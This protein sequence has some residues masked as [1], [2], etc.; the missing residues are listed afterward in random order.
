MSDHSEA[1]GWWLASDGKWYAPG[2]GP[3]AAVRPSEEVPDA[4]PLGN[5]AEGQD[6]LGS[7]HQGPADSEV[8]TPAPP[9]RGRLPIVGMVLDQ[10]AW[11]WLWVIG[12]IVLIVLIVIAVSQVS[13][14]TKKGVGPVGAAMTPTS[15]ATGAAA[16][17]W[18]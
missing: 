15:A 14:G 1:F 11:M 5:D 16:P 6:G 3:E 2:R 12:A 10:G 13:P 9:H 8:V 18:A 7:D 4:A 17:H